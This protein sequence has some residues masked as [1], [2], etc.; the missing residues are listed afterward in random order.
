[1]A[2]KSVSEASDRKPVRPAIPAGTP[3]IL[4]DFT[5]HAAIDELAPQPIQNIAGF[6]DQIDSID[7]E[8][9]RLVN[10]RAGLA[11]HIGRVKNANGTEVFNPA[12]EE[13]VIGRLLAANT[14]PMPQDSVRAIYREIISASRALQRKIQVA[15]L[16]PEF[17]FSHLAAIIRFGRA[18][19]YMAVN[20]I[21]AI[22]EEV[23]R[24][25]V[26][27][28][29]VP[30]ENSTDGRVVDT[31]DM[32]IRMPQVRICSE[33]RLR[34]HHNLLADCPQTEIRR[35]YSKPQALSQCRNWLSRNIPNAKLME[36]SS[37]ADAARMAK[38]EPG[39][40]AVASRDAA[41][42]YGLNL[43]FRDIEDSPHNETRFA[44]IGHTECGRTGNDKTAVMFQIPHSPGSLADI[45]MV[46]KTAKINLTWVESFPY[47]DARG[48]YV[49][50]I[51]F[52]GHNE[53]AKVRR[54]LASL[55]SL[56]DE[57]SVLGSFP[58]APVS[59]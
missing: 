42:H 19:D 47:R 35:I 20:T 18:V 8:I 28:G 46:F 41:V 3:A 39:A 40:A 44:V 38:E 29:V 31:L 54:A 51:E 16:G 52:E 11:S 57:L 55:R 37:T 15:F 26:D 14:G 13:E 6:R 10:E 53:D 48:E 7:S 58:I 12:R 4:P 22:F 33:V 9:L 59:D 27:Y 5:A 2:R 24:K 30:I 45:L 17:T 56:T 1:M 21:A 23:G 43:L 49:F 34:V 32:F 50:F 25:H 36:V